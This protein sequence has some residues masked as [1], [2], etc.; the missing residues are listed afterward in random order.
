MGLTLK[1]SL[2]TGWKKVEGWQE[3]VDVSPD[4]ILPG[5]PHRTAVLL[6]NPATKAMMFIVPLRLPGF[7]RSLDLLKVVANGNRSQGN[8]IS[9]IEENGAGGEFTYVSADGMNTGK[10]MVKKIVEGQPVYVV[11][12]GLWPTDDEDGQLADFDLINASLELA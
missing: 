6:H 1:Y 9:P 8:L 7:I 10:I 11:T 12:I 5:S 2:P 3:K 4:D